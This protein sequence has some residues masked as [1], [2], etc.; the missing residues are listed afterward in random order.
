M[1]ENRW[2]TATAMKITRPEPKRNVKRKPL[3]KGLPVG[4]KLLYLSSV[5]IGVAMLSSVLSQHARVTE[6]AVEIRQLDKQIEETERAKLK[7]ETEKMQLTSPEQIRQF[8]ESRGLEL[9]DPKFIPKV[10]P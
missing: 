3:F 4:E 9:T 6:L 1:R 5:I 2:N 10:K 7:L 8:A